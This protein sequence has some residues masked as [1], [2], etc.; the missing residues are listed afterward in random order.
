M[1]NPETA[2]DTTVT[3]GASGCGNCGC[4]AGGCGGNADVVAPVMDLRH[5]PA[6]FRAGAL[7]GVIATL[8]A[9]GGV[10][11]ISPDD[12]Y[13]LLAQIEAEWPGDFTIHVLDDGPELWS[14]ELMRL[15]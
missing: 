10:T 6:P 11:L 14:M 4:G 9:Q 13:P 12:P 8:P 7:L 1:T 3:D 2:A 15:R 5:L